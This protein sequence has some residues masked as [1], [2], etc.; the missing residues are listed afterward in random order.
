MASLR[1]RQ[2]ERR[3]R[4]I[5]DAAAAL[6]GLKGLDETSMEEIAAQ[7]EVSAATVYNYFGSKNELL[8]ALFLRHISQE[9]EEGEIALRTPPADMAE[10][11]SALLEQY[12]VGMAHRCSPRLA[13]EFYA[14]SV[15]RQFSYG[16]DTLAL[17]RRFFDQCL[18]LSAHYKDRGALREDVTAEEAA[19]MC[20]SAATFPFSM[21]SLG[22]GV[23]VDA[24]RD[25]LRRYISLTIEG[26]GRPRQPAVEA[27][28]EAHL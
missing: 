1:D 10:G 24:A 20:Y 5:M 12:L 3:R 27:R 4:D 26:I 22:M 21:F 2:R 15:S 13:Q 28:H 18:R 9:A 11:M 16:R 17:K 7:A 14:L 23:D 19:T 25:M 6:I 8:Q